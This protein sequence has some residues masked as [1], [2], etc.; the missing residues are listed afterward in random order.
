[1]PARCHV[2]LIHSL[3]QI[4][5]SFFPTTFLNLLLLSRRLNNGPH[6]MLRYIFVSTSIL[7]V[8]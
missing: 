4:F 2:F 1:M 8:R 6:A 7:P 5:I 3:S